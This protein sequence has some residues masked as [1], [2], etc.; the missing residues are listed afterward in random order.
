M[1]SLTAHW[2]DKHFNLIKAVLHSQEFM[3]SD[4]VSAISEAFENMFEAWKIDKSKVH[5][6][7]RDNAGNMAKAMMD[8]SLASQAGC[9]A[10][11]LQLAVHGG[12]VS[13][14]SISAGVAI[15]RKIV[16]LFNHSSLASLRLQTD[17]DPDGDETKMATARH[18]N[19]LFHTRW[20]SVFYMMGTKARTCYIRRRQRPPRNPLETSSH[21]N[22]QFEQ[23][24]RE[25]SSSEAVADAIPPPLGEGRLLSKEADKGRGV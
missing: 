19:G 22:S 9:M 18:P 6:V 17:P 15:G 16:G 10:H 20:N 11:T 25:V 14:R 8:S 1:L 7:M 12:V 2:T 3:G 13:E 4:S 5:A 24:T 23:P 21:F